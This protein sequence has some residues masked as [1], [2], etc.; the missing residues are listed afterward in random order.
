[1]TFNQEIRATAEL[2]GTQLSELAAQLLADEL[3]AFEEQDIRKALGR[4]RR[5]LRG[6]LT[7]AEITSRIP[8]GRPGPDEAWGMI[9]W[10]EAQTVVITTEMQQAQRAAWAIHETD[11]TG[12]RMA[13]KESYIAQCQENRTAHKPVEWVIEQG[14][15]AEGRK[16]VIEEA[17]AKGR[18]SPQVAQRF[19]PAPTVNEIQGAIKLRLLEGLDIKEIAS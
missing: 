19:L 6:R 18:I 8:D 1:M 16:G 2:C 11:K 15:D 17:L 5:E 10:D 3:G 4:C 12:A 13:F 9:A 14:W 7:V